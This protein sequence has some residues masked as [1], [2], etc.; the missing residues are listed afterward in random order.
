MW[1]KSIARN[2]FLGE[3]KIP[4]NNF[5]EAGNSL[6]QP[7]AKWFNLTDKVSVLNFF[8]K[9]IRHNFSLQYRFI[10]GQGGDHSHGLFGCCIDAL[11]NSQNQH[12]KNLKWSVRRIKFIREQKALIEE[13]SSLN[14]WLPY[15]CP[16]PGKQKRDN[17]ELS[18]W[19]TESPRTNFN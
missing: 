9:M 4:V 14:Y 12:Y 5:V 7:I 1:H 8:S 17:R 16:S 10:I 19:R 15:F 2:C 13:Q 18:P 11:P 6:E 3:V